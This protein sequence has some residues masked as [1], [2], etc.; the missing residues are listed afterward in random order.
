MGTG[1]GAIVSKGGLA[2][3]AIAG[4]VVGC[5]AGA[6][7]GVLVAILLMRCL[8]D[9]HSRALRSSIVGKELERIATTST[10]PVAL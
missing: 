2:P 5:A 4:I 6:V 10:V 7:I 1:G 8:R 9:K 3:G